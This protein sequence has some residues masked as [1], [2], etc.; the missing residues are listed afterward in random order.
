MMRVPIRAAKAFRLAFAAF[1][2]ASSVLTESVAGTDGPTGGKGDKLQVSGVYPHLAVFSTNGECGIGAVVPWAG[3]LWMI[4]YPP[5]ATSGS[6]DKLY[7]IDPQL[8]V[9]IRPESVGGTHA[10]RLIHRE[11][12][13]LVIGPYFIDAQG[14]VRACDLSK[15]KGRMTAVAR[16][17]TDPAN[18]V[19]FFDMEGAIYEVD[20]HSLAVA[21]RFEKPVP[22]WHGKGGYT[23][24]GRLV[25]ANN[26]EEAVGRTKHVYL[27]G[28][29][30]RGPEDAGVLAEWDGRAWR[31]VERRQFTDVTGP[32]GIYGSPDDKSPL[33]SIGWDRRSVL[34]MLLDGGQWRRFRLPKASHC[35]DPRHGWYTEWPRIRE[36]APGKLMMDVHGM[37]YDFPAGFRAAQTGGIRPIASHL[38]YVPDFCHWN[39]RLILAT[40]ETS[41]M[42]NPMA[43]QSQSNLW[44]GHMADLAAFGPRSGWGGPWSRDPI[45]AGQPSDPFLVAGFDQRVVHLAHDAASPVTF[46]LEIDVAGDG[47]WRPYQSLVVAARGYRFHVFPRDFAAQWIRVTADKD[48]TATAYFHYASPRDASQDSEAMFA[49]LPKA[50]DSAPV[51][52][53]LIRPAKHNRNLQFAARRVDAKSQQGGLSAPG[54]CEVDQS[55]TF[56]RPEKDRGDEVAKIAAI[57][58][59]FTVD[60]ASV[61]M[62]RKSKSGQVRFR[63]RLPKGSPCY[64]QP[65]AAGWPRGIRECESERYLMNIHGTFYE[66][67]RDS[68]LPLI[69]PVCSHGRQILDFCTWRGLLVLSGN[70]ASARPDGHFFRAADGQAGLW[71]GAIDDL[72]RLGKPVGRGG[73]WHNTPVQAGAP[74]DPY[75]MTGYDKKRIELSHNADHEVIFTVE[76]DINH[77]EWKPYQTFVVRPGQT[78]DHTFPQGFQAHWLRV[79][80]NRDCKATALL[81]YE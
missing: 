17:L 29:D 30:A 68:G 69:K 43:G 14:K 13:Q 63:C 5:H 77:S 80:S 33:W 12:K 6:A 51:L 58:Q 50:A 8:N 53:G 40:D 24:Q 74:S 3:K 54:Y 62:T 38:R 52:A 66:M 37:F 56:T 16:H 26:G 46:T 23:A 73:P 9:T 10:C 72:W 39:G 44:F 11:S 59:D 36:A 75:L 78:V 31:I 2:W 42:A 49:S 20:V 61:V 79:R 25:I 35:Y 19:Y 28:S 64:D 60:E 48:C 18:K 71:F 22:G 1:A 76:V 67:P 32:G 65:F 55:L 41:I 27:A 81:T 57:V 70:L 45:Q 34:L 21:R 15:L 4:T 47:Q 7:E